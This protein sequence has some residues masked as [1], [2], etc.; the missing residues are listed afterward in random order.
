MI[1]DRMEIKT[2]K[3]ERKLNKKNRKEIG[4]TNILFKQHHCSFP[5]FIGIKIKT[6]KLER[7]SRQQ[8]SHLNN[9]LYPLNNIMSHLNKIF[10][11]LIF[12]LIFLSENNWKGN[13]PSRLL[14]KLHLNYPKVLKYWDT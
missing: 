11:V 14:C 3:Q 13:V 6:E 10:V 2:E 4:I 9:L 7:K 1:N 5:I 12:I 8:R